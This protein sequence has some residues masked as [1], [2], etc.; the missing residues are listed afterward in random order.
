MMTRRRF[1][2]TGTVACAMILVLL[3]WSS[4]QLFAQIPLDPRTQTKYVSPLPAP[5]T[6]TGTYHEITMT[7]FQ[8]DLGL[9]D[10]VTGAP[11]MTTVWGYNGTYP[12]PTIEVQRGTPVQ[13]KWMNNLYS[14]TLRLPVDQTLHWADPLGQHPTPDPYTGPIPTIVHLHGGETEP[15]RDGHPDSWFTPDFDIKGAGWKKE[16]YTYHN[17]QPATTLWYHD[18]ALGITRLNVYAGLAGFYII[19]EPAFEAP[20]NLPSGN[21]ERE[22]VIQDR[23]FNADGSLAYP[24]VGIN[25]EHPFWVPEF[26]GNTIVVNGK[27]WPYLEVEPRKYRL[28]FLNGSS[29]RFYELQ[30]I[31][32]LTAM[33]GPAFYQIGTDGGYL[34]APVMLNDPVNPASPKLLIAPGERTDI[35]IDFAGIAAGTNYFLKNTARSPYPKGAPVDPRTTG[36]IMQFRVVALTEPDNS[37]IPATINTIPALAGATVTRTLTL[38]EVMGPGGPLAMFLD[39]KTWDGTIT[40]NPVVGST[41]I[42]EII[43]LTADT[44]PIHL[45]LVQFQPLSRQRFQTNK[46]LKAYN[47]LNPVIPA[48][49]TINPA[50]GPYLQATPVPPDPNEA[51]WKDTFR[52]NPG[53]VSRIIARFA[54]IGDVNVTDYPFDATAE[55]GYVWHC[56]ILEHEDN[57]MMRPYKLVAPP[58]PIAA[59]EENLPES[60]ILGQNY[61][62]PFNP[63]TDIYFSLPQRRTVSLIVYNVLGQ[64]VRVLAE[65]E[66]DAGLHTLHWDGKSQNGSLAASGVYFY[67][68]KTETFDQTMKMVLMK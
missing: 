24:N 16:T 60:P 52:M 43:N 51:G 39:G 4:V 14:P 28:R 64:K 36:Q 32:Q 9:V 68:L 6:L 63:E 62:N 31:D 33:P 27:V 25:P 65:E 5:A 30:L 54:P 42:W 13:I 1:T 10:P 22:I 23:S 46:Y 44:H 2:K 26:F 3:S 61:P 21:Y 17:D 59:K 47:A 48:E 50:I 20:L 40:E 57:E 11:L 55:P 49:S 15:E 34:E 7:E 19:R 12:G 38:N 56:H 35:I 53:E 8:Q 66:M 37:T 67:R 58:A 29:A 41:E 45:H 18:H